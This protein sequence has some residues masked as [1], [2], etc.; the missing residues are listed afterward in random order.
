MPHVTEEIWSHLPDRETRLIVSPWPERDDAVRRRAATRSTASRRRR[1]IF[2]RSGV[3]VE[4][5][6]D[7]ERRIFDA[8]VRPER[9]GA[10]TAT[11]R[12]SA[13]APPR[14]DRARRAHARQRALRRE[15]AGGGRRGGAR[16]SSPAT[17]VSSMPSA[18]DGDRSLGRRPQPLAGGRLRPRPHAGAARAR[19]AIRSAAYDAVHVVGTNGK[20]TATLT[21]E[22]LL[23]RRAD[24]VGDDHLAPRARLGGADPGRRRARP[25]SSAA[26]ERV[27]PAAERLAATQ[28][29]AI[30]AAALAEFA[31]AASRR[32]R[33]RGRPRRPARRDER[34]PDAGRA[35]DERGATTTRRCSARRSRR[36]RR[37]SWRWPSRTA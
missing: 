20:S 11:S 12:P 31:E 29:E 5:G 35:A 25:T 36:S 37:R 7:D 18:A 17:G 21:I 33:G 14:R 10:R 26:V 6:S 4:L 28:F 16:R 32:G 3:R 22:A 13:S 30:T 24:A 23:A 15:G 27:R 9:A 2:R 34:A 1:A 19:W 8:V